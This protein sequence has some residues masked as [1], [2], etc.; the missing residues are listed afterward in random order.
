M[1]RRLQWSLLEYFSGS[2]DIFFCFRISAMLLREN[3]S[4]IPFLWAKNYTNFGPKYSGSLFSYWLTPGNLR[5]YLDARA[6]KSLLAIKRPCFPKEH[7]DLRYTHLN[8]RGDSKKRQHWSVVT[9]APSPAPPVKTKTM[10]WL[11]WRSNNII[12]TGKKYSEKKYIR[13]KE[14]D[15]AEQLLYKHHPPTV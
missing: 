8:F 13:C 15:Q 3:V 12:S 4:F 7:S 1:T 6:L 5:V 11:K 2:D 14:S 9:W 10:R